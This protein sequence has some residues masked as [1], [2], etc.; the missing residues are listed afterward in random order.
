MFYWWWRYES[1]ICWCSVHSDISKLSKTWNAKWFKIFQRTVKMNYL[2]CEFIYN[3]VI[4]EPENKL[5]LPLMSSFAIRLFSFWIQ[6]L[7]SLLRRR[8]RVIPVCGYVPD[9]ANNTVCIFPFFM[10]SRWTELLGWL[11]RLQEI[12]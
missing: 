7:S 4:K 10:M 12:E 5:C 2:V 8:C 3:V 1:F 9:A 6:I 11:M